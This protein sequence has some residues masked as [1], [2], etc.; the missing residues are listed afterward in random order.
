[1][2]KSFEKNVTDLKTEWGNAFDLNVSRANKVANEIGGTE[3]VNYLNSRGMGG[4]KELMK[5]L[6]KVGQT[7]FAEHKF[8]EGEG[9]P[10]AMTPAELDKQ[11]SSLQAN[12]AYF[13]KLHPSHKSIVAEVADLYGKRYPE[14]K[15]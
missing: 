4:D 13:D 11:I 7:M 2:V 10:S 14:Q 6:A 1:M 8:V 15:A 3:L 12:P 5:F 9:T